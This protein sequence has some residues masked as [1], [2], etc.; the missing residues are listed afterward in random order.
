MYRTFAVSVAACAA[1]VAAAALPSPALAGIHYEAVTSSEGAGQN[2]RT[3]VEAWI[4]GEKAKIAF[5]ESG[6][7]GL[8][9]GQYLLT[10][11]GGETLLLVDPKEKAYA[12]WDLAA[13]LQMFGSV[14]Q[15]MG[16]VL[17]FKIENVEVEKLGQEPGG[18]VAGLATTKTRWRTEY[19]LTMKILGMGRTN[20]VETVQEVW[21]TDELA[22]PALGV[23]LRGAS[24]TGFAELDQLFSAEMEKLDG[25]PLKSVATTT[26]TGQ[27]G[28]QSQESR[29]TTEVTSLDRSAAIPESTFEI[30]EGYTRSEALVPQSAQGEGEEEEEGNPFGR[31]LG[32]G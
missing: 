27:K 3:A 30:P 18:T 9:Q 25:F 8:R 31:L 1:L 26:T 29:M 11:D 4:D 19:D 10:R 23:W 5:T 21:T 24:P 28:R 12:E 13:M 7:P 17:N 22:D 15:A 14:L 32:G 16:P 20:H 2:Q 6:T